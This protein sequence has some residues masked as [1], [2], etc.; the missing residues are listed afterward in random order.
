M[1]FQS[2]KAVASRLLNEM[3]AVYDD[4]RLNRSL[5]IDKVLVARANILSKYL[6]RHLGS[7]PG[8]YY[9]EC[10]FD[11]QCEPICP[12]APVTVYRG[13]IPSV[14]AQLGKKA[15]RYLGTVDGKH[16]FEWKDD[17]SQVAEDYT[18][19][20]GCNS[21]NPYFVLTGDKATVYN[22][23]TVNNTTLYIKGVFVDPYAC[24]C[25]EEDIFV[26]AD[27]IDEIEQQ[28]KIDL[29]TYL[30]QRKID[31]MNNAESDN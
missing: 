5:V 3:M 7:I 17:A 12:G 20:S 10:C 29:A 18:L 28:I 26:P 6:A 2:L 16:A 8:Q 22:R 19:F 13:K 24:G 9:N 1:S 15:I 30:I 4:T 11:V 14:L 21:N 31:K 23:P 27:H 25:K